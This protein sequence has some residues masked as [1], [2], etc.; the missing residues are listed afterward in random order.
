MSTSPE[1][2][3]KQI[4]ERLAEENGLAIVIADGE[5]APIDGANNNS[6]CRALYSSEEFAPRC[7]EFCGKAFDWATEAGKPVP[8]ECHAGLNCIAVPL[9][10]ADK[11]LVAIVGR[12]FL[13]S[14]N[15]RQATEKALAGEWRLFPPTR[16]FENVLLT[17]S[18]Q[19]LEK[20]AARLERLS[21]EEKQTL[22]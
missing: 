19:N 6:M 11:P 13:K 14:T 1:N 20:L 15:Y 22:A 5:S 16:F 9:E 17:G 4:I 12:T 8:Y 7:A 3:E 2:I 10:T 21:D 18:P